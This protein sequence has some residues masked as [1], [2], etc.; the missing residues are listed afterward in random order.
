LAFATRGSEGSLHV[1]DARTGAVPQEVEGLPSD[2]ATLSF[3]GD[4]K[5][6][7]CAYGH[8]TALIWDLK[9]PALDK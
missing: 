6:L 2:P 1:L 4:G 5:R 9:V 3:S 7:A 8:G